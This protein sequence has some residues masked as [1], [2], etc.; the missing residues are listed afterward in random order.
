MKNNNNSDLKKL[1]ERLDFQ[2][3]VDRLNPHPGYLKKL[4]YAIG[5]V[6]VAGGAYGLIKLVESLSK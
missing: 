1:E 5:A 2:D 6:A 4:Y 3:N